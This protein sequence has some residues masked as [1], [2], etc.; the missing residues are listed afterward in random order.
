MKLVTL[1]HLEGFYYK[2]RMDKEILRKYS[3][4]IICLSGCPAGELSNALRARNMDQAREIVKE[5]QEIFGKENYFLELMNK[6]SVSGSEDIKKGILSL[7][8]E[9]NIPVV[10]TQDS[11]YLHVDDREAHETLLL[12]NTGSDENNKKFGFGEDDYS[13][14]NTETALIYFKDNP[15]AVENTLKVAD[16]VNIELPL[17]QWVFPNYEIPPGTDYDTVLREKSYQ[18]IKE[19]RLKEAEVTQRIDYELDIIKKKGYAP[20]FLVVADLLDF[21]RKNNILSNTR[22]SAAG[23]LV[24][25]LL[26]ITTVNP[27]LF[28][29]P[30]E[31]FLNPDRPSPPDIDMDFADNRRD[32]VIGYAKQ[33]YGTDKVAQVGT[34]GTMMARGAVRD[35][36]RALGY[37]YTIGDR[38]SKMIPLGS[39]G[40]PMTIDRAFEI[41]PELKEAYNKESDT[42][43][44]LD[45]AKKLESSA[46]HISVHA[47]GVVIAPRE[48]DTWTP[49]QFDPKGGKIITQYDMYSIEDAGL[50]KFDFLGIRNLTILE[51]AIDRVEKIRGLKIDISKIPIDDKKT[52]EMLARG[53]TLATFQLGSSGMT[54]F[55][56]ELKPSTIH[57]INAMVALYRPGPMQFI[58]DYIKRKHNRKLIKYLDQYWRKY[59]KKLMEF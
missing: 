10:A 44:I 7:S 19:R 27:L 26:F 35:V 37:P 17:G 47:A 52:F 15:Q 50:L 41:V 18:G 31:R 3:D 5:H 39:Q 34:F 46:R 23:S 24:S 36:A 48:L 56:K 30:F 21:A 16:L 57:D 54:R 14:I 33:K 43:K 9:F 2:P 40:V 58:P 32:E 25:Y 11:H 8:E 28:E 53:E 29:L 42:K 4:G 12:V 1:S 51:D 20:Y 45:L 13:F 49:L 59:L 55:L 22:G 6:K 38:I